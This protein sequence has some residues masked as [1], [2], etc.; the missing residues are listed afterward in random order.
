MS[1]WTWEYVP[2]AANVV[3]GL[4]QKQI[5]EVESLALRI[6]DAVAVRRIGTPFDVQEA[7]SNVKSYGEGPVMIWFLEDY[8]DDTVLVVRVLHL[9]MSDSA[10]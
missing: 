1:D 4:T 9:G 2:D 7:V 10:D 8:R 3:G 5:D 6:A